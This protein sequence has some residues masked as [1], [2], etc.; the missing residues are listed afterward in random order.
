MK[1]FL[2]RISLAFFIILL[3]NLPGFAQ[4]TNAL[5]LTLSSGSYS[6]ETVVRFLE[7][8]TD[9]FDPDWD[10]YKLK[11][12]GNTPNFFNVINKESYAINALHAPFTDKT[13]SLNVEAAFTGTYTI[14]AEEIGPFDSTCSIILID[15]VLNISQDLRSSS[16]Y[17][18][19]FVNGDPS[20]RF[21]LKF[22]IAVSSQVTNF[23]SLGNVDST[24]STDGASV[25][26]KLIQKMAEG[27]IRVYNIQDKVIIEF[28]DI[29]DNVSLGIYDLSGKEISKAE[30][31]NVSSSWEF[32]PEVK[33]IC[34]VKVLAGNKAYSGKVFLE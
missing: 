13:V 4:L 26:K 21:S 28:T 27:S 25:S 16:S 12:G 18:F 34:I 11:N 23:T 8:A 6:D 33:G 19:D 32:F 31:I 22:Q 20:D 9:S 14:L 5:R 29:S 24:L 10:A 30:N 17:T 1:P 15:K 7:A 3:I 2:K